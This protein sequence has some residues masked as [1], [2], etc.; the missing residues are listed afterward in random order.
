M[1]EVK[2]VYPSQINT[3][4]L[5]CRV[6]AGDYVQFLQD[7]INK[8]INLNDWLLMKVYNTNGKEQAVNNQI[9]QSLYPIKIPLTVDYYSHI[10]EEKQEIELSFDNETELISYIN[11][12]QKQFETIREKNMKLMSEKLSFQNLEPKKPSLMDAKIQISRIA[13]S[14]LSQKEYKEFLEELNEILNELED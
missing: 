8:G 10:E 4:S 9:G 2:K 12:R 1:N 14:K 13:K 5:A 11:K 7:A 3:K 6:P